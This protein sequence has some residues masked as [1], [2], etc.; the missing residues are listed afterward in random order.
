MNAL[1]QARIALAERQ[2]AL[3]EIEQS[4]QFR[5]PHRVRDRRTNQPAQRGL[6]TRGGGRRVDLREERC[7]FAID[8]RGR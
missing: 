7:A 6:A 2:A 8:Q 1:A 3:L 4:R 5:A